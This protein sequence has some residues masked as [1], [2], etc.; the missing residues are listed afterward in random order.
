MAKPLPTTKKSVDLARP[1]GAV[2]RIRR[3]PPPPVKPLSIHD[4]REQEKWAAVVGIIAFALALFAI[5][6]GLS[7]SGVL[8]LNR[9]TISI[10]T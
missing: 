2:S 6:W 8:S 5:L 9:Y 1:A 7:S 10:E 4:R 3:D